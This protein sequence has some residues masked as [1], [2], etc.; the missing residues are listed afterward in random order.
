MGLG[1]SFVC[2]FILLH[3]KRSWYQMP[4]QLS[5]VK[6]EVFLGPS[7]LQRLKISERREEAQL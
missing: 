7:R 1:K 5:V 2:F 3:I 4:D 6:T